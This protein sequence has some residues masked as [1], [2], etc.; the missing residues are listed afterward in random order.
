MCMCIICLLGAPG[1]QKVSDGPGTSITMWAMRTEPGPLQ[2]QHVF[3]AADLYL[4]PTVHYFSFY[5]GTS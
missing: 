1:G 3:L 2:E 4:Y 5:F